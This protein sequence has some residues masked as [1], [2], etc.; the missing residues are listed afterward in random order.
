MANLETIDEAVIL[1]GGMG[2][3]L[4]GVVS[5]VPKPLAPINGIPFL[6]VLMKYLS[7]QGVKRIILAT[8]YMHEKIESLYGNRF[9]D[10]EI[11]YSVEHSPLGTGGAIAKALRKTQSENILILNGD[12]IIKFQLSEIKKHFF[13]IKK[14]FPK[15]K[16]HTLLVLKSLEKVER[17]GAVSLENG[18]VTAFEEKAYRE[19]CL[20]NTGVYVVN[21]NV[22]SDKAED[23]VFSFEK[24]FLE[25]K[26]SEQSLYAIVSDGFFIDIG[27]PEDYAIAQEILLKQLN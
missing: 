26:V 1:C 21:R 12:S 13:E 22:F 20:I 14:Q 16:F 3:R 5:D 8:G 17:Y 19:Q 6:S 27:V 18:I 2:T 15:T 9:E 23:E 25:K 7:L 24:D 10:M 4:R 11:L